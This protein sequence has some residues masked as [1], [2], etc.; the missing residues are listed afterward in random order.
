MKD[1]IGTALVS[2]PDRT[3]ELRAMTFARKQ[4]IADVENW[5]RLDQ[6]MNRLIFR[7]QTLHLELPSGD[8]VTD[9][10]VVQR[11]EEGR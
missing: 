1:K 4:L 5:S 8:A 9:D 7:L 10:A 11:I 6:S 2:A 3:A